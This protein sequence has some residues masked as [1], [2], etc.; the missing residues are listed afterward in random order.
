[1]QEGGYVL[2]GA[3]F[4]VPPDQ[5]IALVLV[6]RARDVIVGVPGLVAWRW[7]V[8]GR[9][10]AGRAALPGVAPPGS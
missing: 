9:N 4:G 6:R 5:A 10:A 1:V 2:I 3:L 8:S 7:S